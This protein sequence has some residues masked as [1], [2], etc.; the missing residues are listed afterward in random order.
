[1]DILIGRNGDSIS[2]KVMEKSL[3]MRSKLGTLRVD[4]KRTRWVHFRNP[5]EFPVDELWLET[6]DRL[7]GTIEGSTIRF[8]ERGGATLEI[9]HRAIHTMVVNPKLDMKAAGLG[10]RD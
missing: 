7:T 2:G 10:A 1:M 6:G 5:P 9:P 8:R 3:T 4:L